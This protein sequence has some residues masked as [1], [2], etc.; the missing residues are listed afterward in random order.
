METIGRYPEL[1]KALAAA[2]GKM[3]AAKF[4]KI[5]PHFK[6]AYA[7]LASIMD[8]CREHLSVNGLAVIQTTGIEDGVLFL[9]TTLSHVSGE[10]GLALNCQYL[11]VAIS[12]LVVNFKVV[13]VDKSRLV[14]I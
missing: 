5:N 12:Q 7:S 8:A 9:Y 4:D 6:S 2:Q 3:R 1:T 10:S 14:V 11:S 13:V